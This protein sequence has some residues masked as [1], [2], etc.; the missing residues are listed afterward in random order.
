MRFPVV[1]RVWSIV[2]KHSVSSFN[3]LSSKTVYSVQDP[4]SCVVVERT[5]EYL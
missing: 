4:D 3:M 5:L 1:I 2:K